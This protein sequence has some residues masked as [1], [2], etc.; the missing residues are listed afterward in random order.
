M[1]IV[2]RKVHLIQIYSK[3]K[4]K[5]NNVYSYF[6]TYIVPPEFLGKVLK[7]YIRA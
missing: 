3:D 2:H 4:L 7:H 1:V 6:T 5:E